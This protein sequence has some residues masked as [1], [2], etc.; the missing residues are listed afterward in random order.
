MCN[1][2]CNTTDY[3]TL[4]LVPLIYLKLFSGT[5]VIILWVTY[6][7]YFLIWQLKIICEMLREIKKN[8]TDVRM[9]AAWFLQQ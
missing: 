5:L 4:I 1:G 6:L 7:C 9:I 8:T 2:R 3:T